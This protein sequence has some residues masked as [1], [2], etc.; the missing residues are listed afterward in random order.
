M[1]THGEENVMNYY[2]EEEASKAGYRP[3]ELSK[4]GYEFWGEVSDE[5]KTA[6]T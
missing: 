5:R 6:D 2:V 1:L 4:H 3:I